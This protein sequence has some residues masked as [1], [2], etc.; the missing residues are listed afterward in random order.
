MQCF[1]L[2]AYTLPLL[3]GLW[4]QS[5]RSSVCLEVSLTRAESLMEGSVG[6]LHRSPAGDRFETLLAVLRE[7]KRQYC[8]G[9][10][11]TEKSRSS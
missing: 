6:I 11:I 9:E 8:K 2:K 1:G 7:G 10:V 4:V 3:L 5:L